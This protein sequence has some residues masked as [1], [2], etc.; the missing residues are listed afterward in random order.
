[1]EGREPRIWTEADKNFV[2][3]AAGLI[4]LVSLTENIET[5]IEQIQEDAQLKTQIVK[6]IYNDENIEQV[7]H[8]VCGK[9][10]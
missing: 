3:G 1:M 7:L 6:G 4:S 5:T 8:D 2:K 10:F 9:S